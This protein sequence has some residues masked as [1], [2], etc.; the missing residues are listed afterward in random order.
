MAAVARSSSSSLSAVLLL[1]GSAKN[2]A[3]SFFPPADRGMAAKA[4]AS[5]ALLGCLW[6]IYRLAPFAR[7][8]ALVLIWWAWEELQVV[9]CSVA[10][11]VDPWDVPL[12]QSICSARI[13]FDLG[14]IGILIVA[15]LAWKLS[16]PVRSDRSQ[17]QEKV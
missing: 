16:I 13:D 15:F 3:W 5:I 1:I 2:Y 9:L 10:Y 12:G 7:L 14:A 8:V 17:D 4:L 11:M 6:I